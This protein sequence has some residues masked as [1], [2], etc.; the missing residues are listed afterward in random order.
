MIELWNRAVVNLD[1][2]I[3]F[4]GDILYGYKQSTE[5]LRIKI[6]DTDLK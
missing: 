2:E 1:K 4:T 6:D 5:P 3:L